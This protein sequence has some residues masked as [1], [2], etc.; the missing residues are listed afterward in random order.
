MYVAGNIITDENAAEKK[1]QGQ[2]HLTAL[3]SPRPREHVHVLVLNLFI[4]AI[5]SQSEA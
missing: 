1:H 4:V 2:H 3:I 5:L